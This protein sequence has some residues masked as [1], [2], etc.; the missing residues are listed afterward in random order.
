MPGGAGGCP[1]AGGWGLGHWPEGAGAG[2]GAG[3]R[4]RGG[5]CPRGR[6]GVAVGQKLT[7]IVSIGL[8][9]YAE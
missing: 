1:P 7:I 4:G 5:G 9:K 2:A 3:D 8:F 6:C